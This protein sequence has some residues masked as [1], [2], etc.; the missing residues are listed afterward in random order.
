MGS[1]L[2]HVAPSPV[3]GMSGI[4]TEACAL[5]THQ[6]C[7]SLAEQAAVSKA[8]VGHDQRGHPLPS[9]HTKEA[10]LTGLGLQLSQ[11]IQTGV[12]S[13][14]ES[15]SLGNLNQQ[16]GCSPPATDPSSRHNVLFRINRTWLHLPGRWAAAK[17]W[18]YWRYLP[19]ANNIFIISGARHEPVG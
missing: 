5:Q 12:G 10:K 2:R 18:V 3:M 7:C 1:S 17:L 8:G 4:D 16:S 9:S 19:P 11:L 15:G 6:G 13:K 14:Y